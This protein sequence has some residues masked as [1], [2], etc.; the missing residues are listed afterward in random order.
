MSNMSIE[1]PPDV[2][3]KIV[4]QFP[5]TQPRL[6]PGI[7]FTGS[8]H[9]FRMHV[10]KAATIEERDMLDVKWPAGVVVQPLED[11]RDNGTHWTK[12][13]RF[14]NLVMDACTK[15]QFLGYT[16]LEKQDRMKIESH[17]KDLHYN[18]RI[19]MYKKIPV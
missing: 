14:W 17:P 1:L 7:I 11:W 8:E 13:I 2:W 12:E 16:F 6:V 10:S 15:A 18:M 3:N 9:H 19:C 4:E 5:A